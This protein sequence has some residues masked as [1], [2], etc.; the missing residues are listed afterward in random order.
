MLKKS[1]LLLP[2]VAVMFTA[3]IPAQ[4]AEYHVVVPAPGKVAPYAAIQ[5]ELSPASLPVSVVGNLYTSFD[6]NSALRITGDPD[7]DL[8]QVRWAKYSGSLPA[9][10]TLNSNGIITGVP[11]ESGSY[12]FSTRATYKTKSSLQS[13]ILDVLPAFEFSP[14]I[15]SSTVD[16]NLRDAAISAGWDGEI[17]IRATVTIESGVQVG[18]SSAASY[19]FSTGSGFPAGSTLELINNGYIVGAGGKGG[20]STGWTSAGGN[21]YNG[22]PALRAQYTLSINNNGVIGGGGG[23]GGGANQYAPSSKFG[24]G[25]GGAGGGAGYTVGAGG[26]ATTTSTGGASGS[27]GYSGTVTAG[28]APGAPGTYGSYVG[29][30]GG[31][32]GGLGAA[33]QRGGTKTQYTGATLPG[34]AGGAG[35]AAVTGNDYIT[36]KEVGTRYGAIN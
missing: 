32:G 3:S 31:Y 25:A 23:G 24:I 29:N 6:F 15:T 13:Y 21:G 26:G 19:A 17:L 12:A 8:S 30:Q 9:G 27:S 14:I 33:G 34:G 7:L 1:L 28:G 10:I 20:V 22:G 11:T 5:L 2:L 16:Y 35:G 18:G 4:A 36:W